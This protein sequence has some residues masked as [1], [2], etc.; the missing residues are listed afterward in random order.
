MHPVH[1][2]TA[3][4]LT[5]LS[6]L[7]ILDTPSGERFERITRLACASLN[8]AKACI[9]LNGASAVHSDNTATADGA[10]AE[11]GALFSFAARQD[12]PMV[13]GDTLKDPRFADNPLVRHSPYIRFYAAYPLRSASGVRLGSFC[14][15]DT[16]PRQL[17]ARE[18]AIIEELTGM[19][20]QELASADSAHKDPSTGL[21]NAAG[22]ELLADKILHSAAR[23]ELAVSAVFFY[24]APGRVDDYGELPSDTATSFATALSDACRDAD[25]IAR[26]DDRHFACLLNNCP[27]GEVEHFLSRLKQRLRKARLS[28]GE[29]LPQHCVTGLSRADRS[30]IKA[31]LHRALAELHTPATP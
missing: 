21:D 8:T 6:L 9:H 22:F 25:L 3:G 10:A 16:R 7:N 29:A 15:I 26:I 5:M 17:C 13:I 23:N 19:A 18:T 2:N 1:L 14:L 11:D 30:D 27:E 24:L 20:E 4:P 28:Q 12:S 31:L